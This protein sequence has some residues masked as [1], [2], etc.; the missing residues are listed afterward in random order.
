MLQDWLEPD[1]NTGNRYLS[2]VGSAAA[3]V[4]VRC[5]RHRRHCLALLDALAACDCT[6][7][8]CPSVSMHWQIARTA[9]FPM[10]PA[11]LQ[12]PASKVPVCIAMAA[13]AAC[14]KGSI[15]MGTR[16]CVLVIGSSAGWGL[17]GLCVKIAVRQSD[18]TRLSSMHVVIHRH[19]DRL[20]HSCSCR[21]I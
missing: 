15:I 10:E 11:L 13:M 21:W 4:C 7:C 18:V 8:Y 3:D 14:P 1:K 6:P 16:S 9:P 20:S 2:H 19:A 17:C 5:H 12:T